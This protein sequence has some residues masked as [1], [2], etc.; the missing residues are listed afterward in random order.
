MELNR[1]VYASIGRWTGDFAK[2][3]EK[4]LKEG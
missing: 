3:S 4:S 1:R 2:W